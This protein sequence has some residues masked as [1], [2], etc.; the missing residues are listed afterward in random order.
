MLVLLI[1]A[2]LLAEA[3]IYTR[4]LWP[5]RRTFA[6][7]LIPVVS[8][9]AGV[10]LFSRLNAGAVL[11]LLVSVYRIINLMRLVKGRMHERYLFQ[12]ARRT[13]LLMGL[14]VGMVLIV[15][16]VH[17]SLRYN[18]LTLIEVFA[19][20]QL[21]ILIVLLLIVIRNVFKSRYQSV[22][23]YY[24]D[25][26]LPTL[27]VAIPARNETEDLEQCLHTIL[28]SDYPKL[29]VIVLDDC[30]QDKTS[31][32]IKKFAHDGVRF[33][34]GAEPAERWLAKNQ[35]YARLADEASGE[36]VLFCG[37]DVRFGPQAI[38]AL[39]TTMLNRDKAMVSVMPKRLT[40]N[41]LEAFIQPMRYWWELALP[42]RMFNR[43]PVL[44][45]CWVIKRRALERIGGFE[46]VSHNVIP[47]GFFA[48]ELT[49]SDD[50]SFIRASDVLGIQT[51]KNASQQRDTAI[52]VRYP[53]VHR[54]PELVMLLALAE[55]AIFLMPFVFL[56]AS[57]WIDLGIIQ[58]IS[59]A[60]VALLIFIHVAIV[61]ISNPAN[62][63]LALFNFP[64]VVL[65]EVVLSHE[66]MF[67]Y[68]FSEVE[69]KGRNVC[70]PVMHITP[71]LPPLPADKK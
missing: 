5:Y 35:A 17:G 55:I 27:T 23:K 34:R 28:A 9:L 29:E 61:Y 38:R 40:S 71:H 36:L 39:V 44:S 15:L 26:E 3:A 49:K 20:V 66:S 52:R 68:E 18:A 62:V 21:S 31:E 16:M 32:I 14:A 11:L 10:M 12:A 67:K 30:S 6:A 24:S 56:L 60:S 43:P 51:I 2:T 53:Q 7:L 47:E 58:T 63:P 37:V 57:I 19:Y 65:T 48:R 42:R 1:L 4:W 46:A 41:P 22:I 45:T 25:K 13:S 8:F 50:Y 54:R 69:W 64:L 33:I 70:I 59:I